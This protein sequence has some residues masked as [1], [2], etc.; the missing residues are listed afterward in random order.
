MKKAYFVWYSKGINPFVTEEIGKYNI[1]NMRIN[2]VVLYYSE[3]WQFV[4]S[5]H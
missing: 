4:L 5:T 1:S 3:I 2:T